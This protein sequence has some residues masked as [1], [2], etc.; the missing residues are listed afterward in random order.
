LNRISFSGHLSTF[1]QSR[2]KFLFFRKKR[3]PVI[4]WV[5][6]PGSFDFHLFSHHSAVEPSRKIFN[7]T[8][9]LKLFLKR[10]PGV[11]SEPG[12]SRVHLFSHFSPLYHWATAAPHECWNYLALL[13][14]MGP[15]GH[16]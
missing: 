12:Y 14:W 10:L 7:F 4:G 8:W 1:S 5:A 2:K 11:G 16:S 13:R 9:M 3:L 6:N 15:E